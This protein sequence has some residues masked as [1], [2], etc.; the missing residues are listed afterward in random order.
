MCSVH[1]VV[2][3]P[4]QTAVVAEL[5]GRVQELTEQNSTLKSEKVSVGADFES[6][7]HCDPHIVLCVLVRS[8]R[9]GGSNPWSTTFRSLE[10]GITELCTHQKI[11]LAPEEA[12]T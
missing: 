1:T 4:P 11:T 12:G 5:E 10:R 9:T 7:T 2:P 3:L 8:L 6:V